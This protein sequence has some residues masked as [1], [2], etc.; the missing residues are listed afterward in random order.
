MSSK[1]DQDYPVQLHCSKFHASKAGRFQVENFGRDEN[2]VFLL[3]IYGLLKAT[4]KAK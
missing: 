1:P 3:L 2:Q 4:K